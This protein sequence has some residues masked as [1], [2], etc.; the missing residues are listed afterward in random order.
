ML[1]KA[2]IQKKIKEIVNLEL[3]KGVRPSDLVDNIFDKN[4]QTIKITKDVKSISME[5]VY[6]EKHV[7]TEISVA[8]T[9]FYD[10]DEKVYLIT[11]KVDGNEAILW[12]REERN[13]DLIV[14]LKQLLENC[15]Y[16][17]KNRIMS[18]LPEKLHDKLVCTA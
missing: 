11:E 8:L 18:S 4:Y 12:S 14:E 6:L 1:D 17:T 10:K 16:S 7:N 3:T 13:R 9:Y 2:V 5:I 15:S